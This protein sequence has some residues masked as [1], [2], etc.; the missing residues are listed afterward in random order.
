M[1]NKSIS[2]FDLSGTVAGLNCGLHMLDWSICRVCVEERRAWLQ[3]SRLLR[4]PR[5]LPSLAP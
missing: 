1:L 2:G 4:S 5:L 3:P